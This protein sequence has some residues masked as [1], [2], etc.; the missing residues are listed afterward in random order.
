MVVGNVCGGGS[1]GNNRNARGNAMFIVRNPSFRRVSS[2]PNEA[3]AAGETQD[4]GS[5]TTAVSD[6]DAAGRG[7]TRPSPWMRPSR[8]KLSHNINPLS[9]T[10]SATKRSAA[11]GEGKGDDGASIE[12][13][14]PSLG[15]IS[16]A[17]AAEDVFIGRDRATSLSRLA[18]DKDSTHD[19]GSIRDGD[20]GRAGAEGAA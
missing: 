20:G 7:A 3:G 6:V 9:V 11:E 2:E 19:R 17:V 1:G 14:S 8:G 16:A 13:S 18:R 12:E 15:A 4:E 5:T 10:A